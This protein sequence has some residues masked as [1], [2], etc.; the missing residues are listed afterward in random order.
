MSYLPFSWKKKSGNNPSAF[1]SYTLLFIQDKITAYNDQISGFQHNCFQ[2]QTRCICIA[3]NN[4]TNL[5][6]KNIQAVF[7]LKIFYS[8]KDNVLA[9]TIKD[10]NSHCLLHSKAESHL[11]PVGYEIKSQKQG[12]KNAKLSSHFH[13]FNI[14]HFFQPSI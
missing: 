11:Q 2:V 12:D 8:N 1:C 6:V 7:W 3:V 10:L 13:S 9:F 14:S 4:C 5:H